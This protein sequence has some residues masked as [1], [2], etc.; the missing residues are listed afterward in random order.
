M[1]KIF[2]YDDKVINDLF[3]LDQP[4]QT[5]W[6]NL[7]PI[8]HLAERFYSSCWPRDPQRLWESVFR[9][10]ENA[11]RVSTEPLN[12]D[13]LTARLQCNLI[14]DRLSYGFSVSEDTVALAKHATHEYNIQHQ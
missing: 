12:S 14:N 6:T 2:P 8:V 1:V 11:Y 13:T 10:P 7:C 9:C 5:R 3:V 4:N